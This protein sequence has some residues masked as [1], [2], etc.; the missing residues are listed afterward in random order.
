MFKN[1]LKRKLQAGKR[2]VREIRRT[3]FGVKSLG[4]DYDFYVMDQEYRMVP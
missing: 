1:T 2:E 4:A 3:V